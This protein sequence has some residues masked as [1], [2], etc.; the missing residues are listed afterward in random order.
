M[1]SRE[2][3]AGINC[4][5]GTLKKR[6]TKPSIKFY[7][8]ARTDYL[9]L[10]S[11]LKWVWPFLVVQNTQQSWSKC[12]SIYHLLRMVKSPESSIT[13]V[14]I[15]HLEL[16]CNRNNWTKHCLVLVLPGISRFVLNPWSCRPAQITAVWRV[17]QFPL[18]NYLQVQE[19][20]K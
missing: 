4:E 11:I 14:L 1:A 8:C 13:T 19:F 9:F 3:Q 17:Y 7:E 16:E 18:G 6:K 10:F 5:E 20:L 12:S 15:L 2:A